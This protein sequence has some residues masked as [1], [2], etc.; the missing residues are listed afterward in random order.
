[1]HP[2]ATLANALW[3]VSNLPAYWQFRRALNDPGEAQEQK[4]RSL[5]Q[6]NANTAFGKAHGF[7]S[8]GNYVEFARHVPLRDYQALEPWVARIRRGEANVLTQDQVTH[9]VPTSGSTGARK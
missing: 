4:L 3:T 5:I 6:R 1:M 7:H 9:L 2:T 8:I